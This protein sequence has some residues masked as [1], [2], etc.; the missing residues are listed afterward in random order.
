[1]IDRY[2]ANLYNISWIESA[3]V[4]VVANAV[5]DRDEGKG[6]GSK[7]DAICIQIEKQRHELR[8]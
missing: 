6:E 1:M 4:H 2:M 8:S 7:R 3:H 5:A